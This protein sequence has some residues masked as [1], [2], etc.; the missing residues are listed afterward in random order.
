MNFRFEFYFFC[1]YLCF[2][3]C[4]AFSIRLKLYCRYEYTRPYMINRIWSLNNYDYR[5]MVML[6][7]IYMGSA[8]LFGTGRERKIQNENICF[9]QDSNSHHASPRQYILNHKKYDFLWHE[10]PFPDTIR[11]TYLNILAN[12]RASAHSSKMSKLVKIYFFKLQGM[13]H[14]WIKNILVSVSVTKIQRL[15]NQTTFLVDK[16]WTI[17]EHLSLENYLNNE[18]DPYSS[19]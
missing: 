17:V 16:F 15:S 9:Q 14:T 13:T 7:F 6:D 10:K 2:I 3:M 19:N 12:E 8:D 5:W 18:F 4:R 11:E 1:S